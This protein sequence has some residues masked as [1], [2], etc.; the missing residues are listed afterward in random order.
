[1]HTNSCI[2]AF[3]FLVIARIAMHKNSCLRFPSSAFT[4]LHNN[5]WIHG[6]AQEL[7]F[8][9]ISH[10]FR[11]L[12]THSN[13]C[14]YYLLK[15]CRYTCYPQNR[16]HNNSC[17]LCITTLVL[18]LKKCQKTFNNHDVIGAKKAP[19]V[20]SFLYKYPLVTP[21][22][23]WILWIKRQF[24]CA[25]AAP[26]LG[27]YAPAGSYALRAS[28]APSALP[29]GIPQGYALGLRPHP[30]SSPPQGNKAPHYSTPQSYIVQSE[31]NHQATTTEKELFFS[32]T[33]S[34]KSLPLQRTRMRPKLLLLA[35]MLFQVSH[36]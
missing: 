21:Q 32:L 17:D 8:R 36:I 13:S 25:K 19:P 3:L 4:G 2:P 23:L 15:T 1:M 24:R 10:T 5:S 26:P 27:G 6:S 28:P 16:T 9:W 31:I 20:L 34:E 12:S 30:S 35:L 33:A 7:N 29:P 18:L 11:R 22:K 14:S